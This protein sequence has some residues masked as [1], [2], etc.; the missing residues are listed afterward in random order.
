[1]CSKKVKQLP[2]KPSVI[3]IFLS[4]QAADGFKAS[5]L[6]RRVAAI[7][8][9]HTLAGMKDTPTNAEVVR[10]TMKG[11]RRSIGAAKEQKS[12][13][14][15]VVL[16]QMVDSIPNTIQGVRDRAILLLGFAGAF[17]RSEL[18]ALRVGDLEYSVNG[19]RVHIRKSKTD[20]EG[21]GQVVPVVRGNQTCPVEAVSLWLK[22]AKIENG[23]VFR[24]LGRGSKIFDDPL[25][26]HSIGQVVKKYAVKVGLDPKEFSGHSLRSGFLTSAAMNGASIF[27]MMDISRH[28]SIQTLKG[29]VR[30]AEEFKN[31]A[32]EGL[33]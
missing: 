28:K 26:P 32:G 27:K 16:L 5:T 22:S 33:L 23:P 3:A 9:F 31:H 24:R 15:S 30:M 10:A 1:M 13:I 20:Q 8:Y 4:S 12:P 11:I 14:T 29:Y 7:R 19:L 17:R 2:A 6:S 21:Q 25:S 18:S